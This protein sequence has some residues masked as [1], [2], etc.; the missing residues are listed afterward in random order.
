[1][2]L[3]ESLQHLNL[4]EIQSLE[5]VDVLILKPTILGGVEKIWQIMTH[6]KKFALEFVLSSSFESS[7]GILTL[8]QIAGSSARDYTAGLDTFKWFKQDLLKEK[9]VINHG[10]LNIKDRFIKSKDINFELLKEIK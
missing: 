2:A 6:A 10:K 9:L 7:L 1:M 4:K 3:D 5:G 8:A